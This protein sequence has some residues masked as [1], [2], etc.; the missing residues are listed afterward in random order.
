MTRAARTAVVARRARGAALA[1]AACPGLVAWLC[2]VT[3]LP[4]AAQD[5]VPEWHVVQPE[6]PT[7]ATHAYV[8]AP[9]V[10]EIEAGVSALRPA[11]GAETDLPFVAKFGPAPRTQLEL[12]WGWT[13]RREQPTSAPPGAFAGI[14]ASGLIDVALALKVRVLENAPVLANF[15]VQPA[16]KL[17]SGS[18]DSVAGTGTGTTDVGLLLISSRSLG[19]FSL[20]LNAG[21]T[22]RSGDGTVAPRTATLLTA[23]GGADLG[24][25]WGFG[26]EIFDYPG[27]SG[28]AGGPPQIGL[29]I[30][31]THA[32]RKWIVVDAGAVVNMSGL[33]A[34]SLYAGVTWNVGRI[35]GWPG[36]R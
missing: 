20:D 3:S 6:R 14:P 10:L 9:G 28:P 16:L 24:R 36:E 12:Q 29:T 8:V 33:S 30:G 13:H 26:L 22:W 19:R 34:G 2:A 27:T 25:G 17:P 4:A 5:S 18:A 35:P 32:V 31:P 7:V 23:S 21:E 11:G 1:R 15:S